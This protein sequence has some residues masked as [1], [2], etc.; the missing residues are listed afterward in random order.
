MR[1]R[2]LCNVPVAPEHGMTKGRV[3]DVIEDD[4]GDGSRGTSGK[5]VVGDAEE[6]VK[7]LYH[8]Y[9]IVGDER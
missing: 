6:R 1:I 9:E 3:F 7:I 4:E 5:W 2:L 8:E